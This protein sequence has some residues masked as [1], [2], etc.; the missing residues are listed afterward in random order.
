VDAG[1]VRRDPENG[2]WVAAPGAE[3]MAAGIL[4]DMNAAQQHQASFWQKMAPHRRLRESYRI[5]ALKIRGTPC[6]RLLGA[7]GPQIAAKVRAEG[8]ARVLLCI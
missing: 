8:R 1:V 2:L 6:L 3:V 7:I 5:H 4:Q